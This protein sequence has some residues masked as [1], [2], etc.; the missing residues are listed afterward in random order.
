MIEAGADFIA[1][2]N[3]VSAMAMGEE[4]LKLLGFESS[5]ASRMAA[6]F[7]EHDTEGM[8][9]LYEVWGDEHEYGL[10]IRENLENLEQVLKADI[11]DSK[12]R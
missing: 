11:E 1:R 6:T 3:Y 2:E 10:R 8:H 4:A 9:K 5:R 12:S 7:D